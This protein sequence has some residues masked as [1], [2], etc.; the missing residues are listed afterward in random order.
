MATTASAGANGPS[1][2][3]AWANSPVVR[4]FIKTVGANVIRNQNTLSLYRAWMLTQPG[5]ARSGYVGSIDHLAHKATTIMWAGPRTPLLAKIISEGQRRGIKVSVQHRRES[6]QQLDAAINAIYR[7]AAHGEWR[8]FKISAIAAVGAKDTGLTVEGTYTS[9]PATRRAP[10]VKSLHTMVL[11]VRVRV[12][13]GVKATSLIGRDNDSAPFDAGG[14]MSD[15]ANLNYCTSGF[16]IEYAGAPH[17]TTARHCVPQG[18]GGAPGQ[19]RDASASN[20]YGTN[21]INS[22]NGAGQVLSAS[23]IAEAWDGAYN[24]QN[25]AKAVIGYEDLAVDDLVCTGG[26]NSGE[27]CM[28]AVRN[29]RVATSDTF[30][31]FN[32]IEGIQEDSTKISAMAGDSGGP[33]ISLAGTSSGQVR[34]AGMIQRLI[35]PQFSGAQACG[36]AFDYGPNNANLCGGTVLFTSM[37][38]IVSSLSG[39]SLLTP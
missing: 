20:V 21:V 38:T 36:P 34:A 9:A 11:G 4:A 12:V 15:T 29:L 1:K 30:G 24:S 19:W 2:P 16:A 18:P 28:I 17:T 14:L 31:P 33:V 32:A 3:A 8:G 26:G 39:A 6:L 25:F 37:R 35:G 7:Q 27:H 5:F 13:P 22:P 10:Q 23:G